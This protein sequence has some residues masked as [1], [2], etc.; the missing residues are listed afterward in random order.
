MHYHSQIIATGSYVPPRVVTNKDLEPLLNTTD[1]WIRE[2]I[3]IEERRYVGIDTGTSDLAVAAARKALSKANLKPADIDCIV[4]ATSTP[5]HQSPGAGVLVQQKLG[6]RKI[7]AYDIH[8]TSPGFLFALEMGDAFIKSGK[9][10]TILVLGAE[11]HSTALDMTPRGRMMSVIFGD[12]AGAVILQ[13]TDSPHHILAT[14]LHSDGTHFNKL[15]C[16][17]PASLY[18]PWINP[19]LI[20]QGCIHPTMDGRHVFEHAVN[21]MSL[22]CE[23]ILVQQNLKNSDINWVIPHQANL[24]IIETIVQKLEIPLQKVALTIQKYGN[25]SS[26]SI[27]IT[28]DEWASAGNVKK[29]DLLLLTSF[30][31]GYSWGAGLIRW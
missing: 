12:G 5:D 25:T 31:S 29:N 18:H 24:R 6:C 27:P 2:K 11:V 10:E 4:M 7:P 17:A 13:S 19:E 8:N 21:Y 15:W 3:G 14:K 20:E 22:V 28:I 9:Y 23:E 1:A 30:G 26:A 16:E